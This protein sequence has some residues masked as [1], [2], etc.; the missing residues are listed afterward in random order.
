MSQGQGRS[1]TALVA[2]LQAQSLLETLVTQEDKKVDRNRKQTQEEHDLPGLDRSTNARLA[3]CEPCRRSR[4]KCTPQMGSPS[5]AACLR[6]H[7]GQLH[8]VYTPINRSGRKRVGTVYE[9]FYQLG[10]K[11]VR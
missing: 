3:A 5:N 11:G 2:L 6:C 9:P 4:T 1:A 8:C 7:T 10:L